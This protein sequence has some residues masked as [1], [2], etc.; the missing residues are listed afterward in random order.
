MGQRGVSQGSGVKFREQHLSD[1]I[2]SLRYG[3]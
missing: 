3:I 1:S 2:I